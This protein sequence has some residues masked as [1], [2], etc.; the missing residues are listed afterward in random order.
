MTPKTSS[1][2]G[3]PV[4]AMLTLSPGK[5]ARPVVLGN[6]NVQLENAG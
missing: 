5:Y 6:E 4:S 1:L 2:V 3:T